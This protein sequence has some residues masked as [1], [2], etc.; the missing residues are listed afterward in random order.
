M[1]CKFSEVGLSYTN[2]KKATFNSSD[3]NVNLCQY[4]AQKKYAPDYCTMISNR[5][6]TSLPA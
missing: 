6:T 1:N 2:M 3:L 5:C 4:T